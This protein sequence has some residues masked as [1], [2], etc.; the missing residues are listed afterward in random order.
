MRSLVK[1]NKTLAV[2]INN[3]LKEM[4]TNPFQDSLK[5]HKVNTKLNGV[6]WSS[7]GV[8]GDIRII[9]DFESGLVNI[10]SIFDVGGHTGQNK[11]YK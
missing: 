1:R 3:V 11:V 6:R 9:W 2:L 8:T 4:E 7:R 10:V 5:S